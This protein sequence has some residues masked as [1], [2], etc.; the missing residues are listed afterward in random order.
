[1]TQWD[2]PYNLIG[3]L[4]LGADRPL[5]ADWIP[6]G[7]G[8]TLNLGAGNKL[9]RNSVALDLPKWDADIDP[10]PYRD[11]AVTTIYALHFF[12][13]VRHPINLLRE[14]QRVLKPGGHLNV[15]VPH[16]NTQLAHSDLDHKSSWDEETWSRI[17][18]NDYY[19]KNHDGWQFHIGTNILM[20]IAARNLLIVT[21]LIRD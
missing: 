6:D 14:C 20:G 4:R 15:V 11:G 12:E 8:L 1:M 13:H 18:A 19:E 10:I 9:I 2:H 3:M 7:D 16:W 5:V 17:L 21:Q